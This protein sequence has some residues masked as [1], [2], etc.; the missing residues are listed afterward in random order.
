MTPLT[1]DI[2]KRETLSAMI[3]A[4][5]TAVADV[6]SAYATL[7]AAQKRLRDTFLEP[8]GYRFKCND[9]DVYDCGKAASDQVN[10]KIKRDAWNA[11]VARM[12]LRHALSIK[13]REELDKQLR[14]GELPE[15]TENNVLAM[16]EQ[17]AA[18]VETYLTE[19][20][21][22][23]YEYLRP[24][25]SQHKTNTEFAVGKRVILTWAVEKSWSRGTDFRVN[26]HRQKYITALDNV[27][28]ML[29]GKGTSKG[30]NGTLCDTISTSPDGIGKT[31]YFAFKCYQNGNLHLEFLRPELV[32][33]LNVVAGGNRLNKP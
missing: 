1:T 17:S 11:I 23:V 22:E 3:G 14:E 6:E 13:R 9:R 21:A 20:V 28:H 24:H 32:E 8:Q 12:E 16:F 18:N 10:A 29:D 26:H 15:L 5:T 27:F 30:Y 33:R 25:N 31:T 4:Y 7:D 19:A 2:A